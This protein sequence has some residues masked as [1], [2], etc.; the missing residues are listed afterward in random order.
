MV[1][2]STLSNDVRIAQREQICEISKMAK[3]NRG[4]AVQRINACDAAKINL[5]VKIAL[6][7]DSCG[8]D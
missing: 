6:K 4:E 8:E 1:G 5:Q 7:T 3:T 2:I